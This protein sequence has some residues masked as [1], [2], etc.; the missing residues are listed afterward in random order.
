MSVSIVIPT[1]MRR[2]T[3]EPAV[4]AADA[5]V[6]GMP[7]AEVVVV[8]NGPRERRRAL[9]LRSPRL[10]V[11][12]CPVPRTASARN[13][14]L[15]EARNDA[16]LFTDDDCIVSREWAERLTQRLLEGE[17]CVTTPLKMRRDG[18]VTTFL[19]YQRI[20]HPRPIDASTVQFAIGACIAVRRDLIGFGFDE[21]LEAGDD[22]QFGARLRDQGISTAYEAKGPPPLHLVPDRI[23]SVTGRF[24]QYGTSN[25]NNLLRKDRPQYSVPYAI[26]LYASLCAVQS[27]TPR[28]FEEITDPNLRQTF[29]ALEQMLVAALLAG[30]LNQA[31]RELGREIIRLDR[32]GLDAGWLEI[33]RR[34][35]EDFAWTGDWHRLPLDYRRWLTPRQT[36]AP[37]LAADVA[38]NVRRNA[39]LMQEPGPDPDLDRGG[40]EITR[41]S[42]KVWVLVNE[43]WS[44]VREGRLPAEEEAIAGRLRGAGVDFRDGMQTMEA[45]ALGPVQSAA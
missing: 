37:V 15:R 33:E 44:D 6:A 22:A 16:I 14:G 27:P 29:A 4:Q 21:D 11:I 5:A 3:L 38:D 10:S 20:F 17:V 35:H 41:K 36:S 1:T 40:G 32:E 13:V 18:P 43:A 8:A 9:E 23:Q 24:F 30:Y 34:L 26:P 2:E 42:E 25:A 39:P 28:R 12:E 19:D 7:G 45:I 31:G